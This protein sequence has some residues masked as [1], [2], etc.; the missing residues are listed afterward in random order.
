VDGGLAINAR[1]T[2]ADIAEQAAR[3]GAT[4]VNIDA[5]RDTGQVQI[6][7]GLANARINDFLD[8]ALQDNG[9]R[10][11]TYQ[12]NEVTVTISERRVPTALLGLIGIQEFTVGAAATARAAVGIENEIP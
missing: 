7:Q 10:N 11:I 6:D 2:A 9:N 5:L 12:G 3:S 1:S 4:E 8:Q